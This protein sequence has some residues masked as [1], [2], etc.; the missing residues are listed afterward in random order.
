[1]LADLCIEARWTGSISG[2][3]L[4]ST[5]NMLMPDD[6]ILVFNSLSIKNSEYIAVQSLVKDSV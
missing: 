3:L 2:V 5:T 1:M 4:A 6:I